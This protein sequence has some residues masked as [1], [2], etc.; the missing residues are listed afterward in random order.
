MC[1]PPDVP[2]QSAEQSHLLVLAGP[3]NEPTDGYKPPFLTWVE[4][5]KGP[6]KDY[7][8]TFVDD[9]DTEVDD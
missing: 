3:M 9:S 1:A 4:K 2:S 7:L 8:Y 5:Q 6:A